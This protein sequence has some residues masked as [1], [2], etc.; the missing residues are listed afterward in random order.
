MSRPNIWGDRLRVWPQHLLPHHLLS[1][2]MYRVMRIRLRPVKN[3]LIRGVV[4]HYDVDLDQ[5]ARTRIED[6]CHFNDF[7]TRALKPDARPISPNPHDLSCPVDGAISL[8]GRTEDKQTLRAKGHQYTLRDL[9]AGDE[10]A[11]ADFAGGLSGT[12]YLSPRDYHRIHAPLDVRVTGMTYVPGRLF[13]VNPATTRLVSGLFA[14]NERVILDMQTRIGRMMLI[15]VGAI[16]VSGIETV[17]H[18]EV[19]PNRERGIRHWDY[20]DDNGPSFAKGEELARFNM[21]STVILLAQREALTWLPQW[22]ETGTPVRLG[23]T[24]ARTR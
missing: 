7:F 24:L 16:F 1:A 15:C 21:G 13:S 17:W 23:Q 6:Y 2:L 10:Q 12:I 3:A 5:A 4:K 11:A 9:L 19:V 22:Q 8:L 18:G 20:G 14:R